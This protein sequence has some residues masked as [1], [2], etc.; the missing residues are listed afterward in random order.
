MTKLLPKNLLQ[1]E[2]QILLSLLNCLSDNA[3]PRIS[4]NIK[5]EGLRIQPVVIRLAKNLQEKKIQPV[6]IWPDAGATALA[7]RDA[8]VFQEYIYS[9]SDI[10]KNEIK[11]LDGYVVIAVSPQPYD[12]EIFEALCNKLSNKVLMFN[13]KLDDS[14][15]GI[16]SVA[17]ERRKNFSSKWNNIYWLEPLQKGALLKLYKEN[18][19]LFRLDIDGYRFQAEYESKPSKELI[20]ETF[21]N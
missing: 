1:A 8:P 20:F 4:I 7:K 13:G 18:W 12:Y 2:E 3:T 15:V 19:K 10:L 21:L 5:L 11:E 14:A 16:G 17:R 9:F 6:L